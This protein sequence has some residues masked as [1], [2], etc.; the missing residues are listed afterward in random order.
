MPFEEAE[1]AYQPLLDENRDR[2]LI[3]LLP[4]YLQEEICFPRSS[5]VRFY[6]RVGDCMNKKV[7]VEE[8]DE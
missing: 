5:A 7:E 8:E 2:D 4:D 3:A 1:F 6:A